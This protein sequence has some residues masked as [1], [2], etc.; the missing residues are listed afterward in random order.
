MNSLSLASLSL[1]AVALLTTA[2]CT[3]PELQAPPRYAG[4]GAFPTDANSRSA[5]GP[6][7]ANG[8][9]GAPVRADVASPDSGS[10]HVDNKIVRACGDVPTAHF[11]FNSSSVEPEAA[12]ALD[13]IAR[14]FVS[15]A[16]RGRSMKLVG[17]AD[18]RGEVEYNFALGQRRAGNVAHYLAGRGMEKGHLAAS[19][20]GEIDSTGTDEAGWARDRKV[21]VLLAD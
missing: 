15:G 2:G 8:A 18:P 17:H 9:F 14:C 12:A 6:P 13:A 21:D 7:G 3:D 20:R 16:L 10:V 5:F 4:N 19:S 1:A 11:A